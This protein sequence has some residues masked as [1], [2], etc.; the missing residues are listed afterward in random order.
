MGKRQSMELHYRLYRLIP[1]FGLFLHLAGIRDNKMATAAA[2][3]IKH[4]QFFVD[5]EYG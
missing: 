5:K 1:I 3:W 4:R 2:E